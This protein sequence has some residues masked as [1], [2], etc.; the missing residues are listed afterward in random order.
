MPS[1]PLWG[2]NMPLILDVFAIFTNLNKYTFCKI[3]VHVV[4]S[5]IKL[6]FI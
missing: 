4:E 1:R 5:H 6:D 3:H 2:L